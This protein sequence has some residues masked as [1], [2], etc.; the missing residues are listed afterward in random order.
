[1]EMLARKQCHCFDV[2]GIEVNIG[3]AVFQ[4]NG[5]LMKCCC[6]VLVFFQ[7]S[8]TRSSALAERPRDASRYKVTFCQRR[9]L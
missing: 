6:L 9:N 7:R 5:V 4:Q 8:R 2:S 3:L 1:V